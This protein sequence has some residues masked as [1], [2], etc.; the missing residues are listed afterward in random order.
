MFSANASSASETRPCCS[1]SAFSSAPASR[2]VPSATSVPFRQTLPPSIRIE[3]AVGEHVEERRAGGVDET[4]ARA[5]ELER[6]RGSGT[7]PSWSATR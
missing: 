6:A 5:H 3:L 2:T 1:A 4:D 7:G